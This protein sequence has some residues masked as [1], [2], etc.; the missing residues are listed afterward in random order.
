MKNHKFPKILFAIFIVFILLLSTSCDK[1][2]PYKLIDSDD[3]EII[4]KNNISKITQIEVCLDTAGNPMFKRIIN[5]KLYDK[6]GF[7]TQEIVPQYVQKPWIKFENV[8]IELKYNSKMTNTNIPSGRVDTTY[9]KYDNNGNLIS[10]IDN[11]IQVKSKYDENN[12]EIERCVSSEYGETT[13]NYYTYKYDENNKVK[14]VIDSFGVDG[15]R[16]NIPSIKKNFKY[17][18]NDRVIFDGDYYKEYNERGLLIKFYK[19]NIDNS[20][21][22]DDLY[23]FEYDNQ[24]KKVVEK[25]KLHVPKEMFLK[26]T[27]IYSQISYFYYNDKGLITQRKTLD[28]NNNLIDLI[29]YEYDFYN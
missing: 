9:Y 2:K 25:I 20:E 6:N 28:N 23:E 27:V 21:Y 24:D 15:G 13:C 10:T 3:K 17:D 7:L 11:N 18:K 16:S 29:N 26:N 14:Y 22:I 8:L 12:N 5:Y 4:L 1:R 19:N